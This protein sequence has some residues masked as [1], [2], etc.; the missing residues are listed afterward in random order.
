MSKYKICQCTYFKLKERGY[1]P[2]DHACNCPLNKGY[3]MKTPKRFVPPKGNNP[4]YEIDRSRNNN[5]YAEDRSIT[6]EEKDKL[7]FKRH[8]KYC[9]NK[10]VRDRFIGKK[11]KDGFIKELKDIFELEGPTFGTHSPAFYIPHPRKLKPKKSI[12][13]K[14]QLWRKYQLTY[15]IK[16]GVNIGKLGRPKKHETEEKSQ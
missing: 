16:H 13:E 6:T 8:Q 11:V 1:E 10:V 3:Y 15:R 9:P 12:E 7:I 4:Y 14:R 2:I 5:P